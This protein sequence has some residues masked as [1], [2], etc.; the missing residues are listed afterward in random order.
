MYDNSA[1]C[2]GILSNYPAGCFLQ[3]KEYVET[4]KIAA[5]ETA[6]VSSSKP[7]EGGEP[8][9]AATAKPSAASGEALKFM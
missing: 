5:A 4:G 3:I 8:A 7:E 1:F 9:A 2:V 6:G